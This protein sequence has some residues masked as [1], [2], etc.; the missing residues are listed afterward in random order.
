MPLENDIILF[1][2]DTIAAISTTMG[3][4]AISIIRISGSKALE[5]ADKL[6]IASSGKKLSAVST[7]TIH[8]GHI[9]SCDGIVLDEVNSKTM[10]IKT[11]VVI[12][13]GTI[14]NF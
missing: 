2:N 6:F 11:M 12:K 7:H 9:V 8:H 13:Q 10:E 5:I 4:G 1:S 14:I 3:V